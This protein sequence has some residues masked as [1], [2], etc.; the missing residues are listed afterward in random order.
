[1]YFLRTASE[2]PTL[3]PTVPKFQRYVRVMA[4][5][6][7]RGILLPSIAFRRDWVPRIQ[8]TLKKW[9]YVNNWSPFQKSMFLVILV[10]FSL[11]KHCDE[12]QLLLFLQLLDHHAVW[13]EHL[14]Q[15]SKTLDTRVHLTVRVMYFYSWGKTAKCGGWLHY[16]PRY[17]TSERRNT[18]YIISTT[19]QP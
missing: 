6:T 13:L 8:D 16:T 2:F 12:E 9:K 5:V 3:N 18:V 4:C 10:G 14:F 19:S 17:V 1:M 11:H 7:C 15:S